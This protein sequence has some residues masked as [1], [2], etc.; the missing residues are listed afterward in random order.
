M[1]SFDIRFWY[2]AVL[3]RGGA[4]HR[5][6]IETA[7]LFGWRE[8]FFR[9]VFRPLQNTRRCGQ[10]AG[11]EHAGHLARL[12]VDTGM[13]LRGHG[14]QRVFPILPELG[15]AVEDRALHRFHKADQKRLHRRQLGRI[16]PDQGPTRNPDLRG[17]GT[18]NN[19]R[20]DHRN[21]GLAL[22]LGA[23]RTCRQQAANQQHR[24]RA[25]DK[26][27]LCFLHFYFHIRPVFHS[28]YRVSIAPRRDVDFFVSNIATTCTASTSDMRS[29]S[30]K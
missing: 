18:G 14:L 4:V 20:L 22:R 16:N 8:L 13:Q 28:G 30:S 27:I 5:G 29:S 25:A 2:C 24:Q 15:H 6:R 19:T 23:R 7:T 3:R 12:V 9:A 11:I 17:V 26:G 1:T 10:V 21:S